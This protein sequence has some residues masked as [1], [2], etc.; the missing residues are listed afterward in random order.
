MGFLSRYELKKADED[1]PIEL[2]RI[3]NVQSLLMLLDDPNSIATIDNQGLMSSTDKKNLN[4][5]TSTNVDNEGKVWKVDSGT[6]TW[7]TINDTTYD[8]VSKEA[9]GLAPQLPDEKTTTKYLRQDATWAEPP[10]ETYDTVSK[11]AAG[12]AP[13]LPSETA[14]TKY[15]RQ[16]ASWA[17]P[18]N[19]NTTYSVV[20]TSEN[21]LVLLLPGEAA[22]TKFFRG[23]A[24]WAVPK[25]TTYSNATTSVA[26]LMSTTDKQL[27][28]KFD[29]S[30]FTKKNPS[31]YTSDSKITLDSGWYTI[32]VFGASGGSVSGY[33]APGGEGG[34]IEF[35]YFVMDTDYAIVT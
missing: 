34:K 30:L 24:S 26:S 35:T 32:Q 14:T 21:G 19:D 33:P 15:L 25:D 17:V 12:L 27:L 4:T 9:D 8:V 22:D 3:I 20:S 18:P 5:L 7:G 16:D 31:S 6:P 1:L 10:N 28:N 2:E 23:D 29:K 13:I 11:T